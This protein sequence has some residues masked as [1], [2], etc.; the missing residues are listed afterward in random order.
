MD[1]TNENRIYENFKG[2]F[3][4][5]TVI[6]VAHRLSTVRQ[7]NQILVMHAGTVV[8]WGNHEE[9]ISKKGYYYELVKNQIS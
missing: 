3:K 9:L 7:A 8:E 6:T 2:F 4:G 5:K 1:A